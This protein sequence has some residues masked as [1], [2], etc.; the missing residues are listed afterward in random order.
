MTPTAT[1]HDEAVVAKSDSPQAAGDDA[2]TTVGFE[3]EWTICIVD[4]VDL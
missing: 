1:V 3:V 2:E 4:V